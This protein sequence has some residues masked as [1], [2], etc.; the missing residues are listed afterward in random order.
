MVRSSV[1]IG[2]CTER[3]Q[4]TVTDLQY[5]SYWLKCH[6]P[7]VH[8]KRIGHLDPLNPVLVPWMYFFECRSLPHEVVIFSPSLT[9]FQIP[10][11]AVCLCVV[12]IF[13]VRTSS[14]LD[15]ILNLWMISHPSSVSGLVKYSTKCVYAYYYF[16]TC[17]FLDFLFI[18]HML[19]TSSSNTPEDSGIP[20]RKGNFYGFIEYFSTYFYLMLQ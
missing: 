16:I 11:R 7:G 18:L 19:T 6:K 15:V 5:M 17:R 8:P 13:P 1:V 4:S 12:T 2:S 14:V 10:S 9:P 3:V 20:E